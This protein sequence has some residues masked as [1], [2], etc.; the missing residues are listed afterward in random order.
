M[1]RDNHCTVEG[2]LGLSPCVQCLSRKELYAVLVI[3]L[4]DVA[5][6]NMPDDLQ[7]LLE[8]SACFRCPSDREK[9]QMIV[10]K[11]IHEYEE[12][13]ENMDQVRDEIKCVLCIDEASLKGLLV[14]LLCHYIDGC[15]NPE[16]Q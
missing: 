3:I 15:A 12:N 6:Y 10:S 16:P 2:L 5:G 1:A 9:L 11:F 7:D 8:D 13:W 14:H 4:A